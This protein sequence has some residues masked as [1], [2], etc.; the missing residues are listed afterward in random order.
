MKKL[1]IYKKKKGKLLGQL[2]SVWWSSSWWYISAAVVMELDFFNALNNIQQVSR[3][4]R[5]HVYTHQTPFFLLLL[6]GLQAQPI[7]GSD[8]GCIYIYAN[9]TQPIYT[10]IMNIQWRSQQCVYTC[11]A[12]QVYIHESVLFD[13]SSIR[14]FSYRYIGLIKTDEPNTQHLTYFLLMDVLFF[15]SGLKF[16]NGK[17]NS[18]YIALLFSP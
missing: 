13:L 4:S 6:W 5:V 14:F 18:A 2:F 1:N 3:V 8:C 17:R 10:P 15:C 11:A 7:P 16:T 12:V 9:R